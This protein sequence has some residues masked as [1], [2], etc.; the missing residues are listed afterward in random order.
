MRALVEV[1]G[2][3]VAECAAL[4]I[5]TAAYGHPM[6]SPEGVWRF[7][8]GRSPAPMVELGWK[9]VGVLELTALPTIERERWV[10]WVE[11]ADVL[12]VDGGDALYLSHWLKESGLAD[13]LPSLT[14]AWVGL[15]A[16]S[17]ALAPQIGEEFIAQQPPL[18]GSD[19]ALGLVDFSLFPHL[20][21]PALPWNTMANAE[22]WAAK[23]PGPAYAL[24]DASAIKVVD[25]DVEVVSEGV[26]RRFEG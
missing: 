16:G 25:G 7:V 5:P 24:D 6:V 26:W 11:A 15:S 3:P 19:A 2:K 12:L 23:L 18:T 17:M 8:S 20:G 22:L 10:K 1:L 21:H 9:S 4:C 13:M 14:C